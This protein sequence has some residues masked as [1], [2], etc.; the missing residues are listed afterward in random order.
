MSAFTTFFT[1]LIAVSS[2]CITS[3]ASPIHKNAKRAPYGVPQFALDYAPLVWL[4][5]QDQYRPSDIGAQL[6]NS[7]PEVNFQAVAGA[8]DPLTLDNLGELNVLGG[9]SVFLTAKVDAGQNPN[10]DWLKGVTPDGSGWT[11]GAT[12]AAIIVNQHD[13]TTTDVFYM[14]FYA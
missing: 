1:S 4:H 3:N 5:S 6:V 10:Q 9:G 7:Q 13:D 12:S 2:I 11:N 8:P 14:Y